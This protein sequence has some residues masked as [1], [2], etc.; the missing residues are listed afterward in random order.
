M[1]LMYEREIHD[2]RVPSRCRY[3]VRVISHIAFEGTVR[4]PRVECLSEPRVQHVSAPRVRNFSNKDNVYNDGCETSPDLLL[5]V[6]VH[7]HFARVGISI[8]VCRCW[9]QF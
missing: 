7:V 3:R 6:E 2:Y 1:L 4:A 8:D 9:R 5:D